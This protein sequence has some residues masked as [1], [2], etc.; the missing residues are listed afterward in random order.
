MSVCLFLMDASHLWTI[1]VFFRNISNIS[2]V[3]IVL[4]PLY[5]IGLYSGLVCKTTISHATLMHVNM[6]WMVMVL[7]QN[8]LEMC[9]N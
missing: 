7:L 5:L 4:C 3:T 1:K 9:Q 2:E 8:V 6:V